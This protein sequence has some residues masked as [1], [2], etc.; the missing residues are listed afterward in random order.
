[1]GKAI[2]CGVEVVFTLDYAQYCKTRGHVLAGAKIVDRSARN[3]KDGSLLLA[4][5]ENA[6]GNEELTCIPLHFV[7]AKESH[8]L[9]MNDLKPFFD[10]GKKCLNVGLGSLNIPNTVP[11]KLCAFPMDMSV[12]QK[13]LNIGGV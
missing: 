5:G 6:Q 1:M 9:F 11:L 7:N 8:T 3:P 12:E 10:F 2:R 4:D 13:C